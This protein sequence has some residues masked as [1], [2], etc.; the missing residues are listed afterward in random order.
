MPS[1]TT[2]WDEASARTK[3]LHTRKARQAID[4]CLEEIVLQEKHYILRTVCESQNTSE[5]IDPML[6]EALVEC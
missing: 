1:F 4:A 5:N 2:P 6:L 3:R